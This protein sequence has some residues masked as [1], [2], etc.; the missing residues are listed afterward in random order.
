MCNAFICLRRDDLFF[1]SSSSSHSTSAPHQTF[2]HIAEVRDFRM[3]LYQL[4]DPVFL[5]TI[6]WF[7][8][9]GLARASASVCV[10]CFMLGVLVY[11]CVCFASL[12][13][14][15]LVIYLCMNACIV[16]YFFLFPRVHRTSSA[17][18]TAPSQA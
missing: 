18:S 3:V 10:G 17:I 8:K 9:D 5:D 4:K 6:M 2:Q 7:M 15:L 1:L 11:A 13:V 14:Y 16:S 12:F